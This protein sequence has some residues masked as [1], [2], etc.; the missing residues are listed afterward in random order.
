M[1]KFGIRTGKAR[2]PEGS[3]SLPGQKSGEHLTLPVRQR[4]LE[5]GQASRPEDFV[6]TG[7]GQA[8]HPRHA[9]DVPEESPDASE[10]LA[11][12]RPGRHRG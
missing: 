3:V 5:R 9:A 11:D 8:Y 6:L 10:L 1:M 7:A 12:H 2:I 4:Q